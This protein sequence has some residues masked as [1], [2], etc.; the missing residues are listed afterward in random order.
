[1]PFLLGA[2][3]IS[4]MALVSIIKLIRT[5]E[6][7]PREILFGFLT[8]TAIFGLIALSYILEG[9]AW[10]LSPA[11]RL[12]IFMIFI[13]FGIHSAFKSS[14]NVKLRYVSLLFLISIGLTGVLGTIFNELFFGLIDYLGVEKY[15]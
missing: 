11:F 9:R 14:R 6:I 3:I 2:L 15:Y 10:A 12:P 13:P 8:S 5:K 7:G 1:M 4:I